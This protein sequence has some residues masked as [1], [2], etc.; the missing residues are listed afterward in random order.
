MTEELIFYT[1][2]MSRGRV[3]RWMLEETGQSYRTELLDYATTMKAPD[4]LNVNPMGKVPTIRHGDTVV[5]E[6]AAICAYLAD[7]FPEAGLA[8]PPGDRLRGRY[9]RWLFFGAGPVEAATTNKALGFVLPAG[10]ERLAGYG[11][12]TDVVR[13]LEGAVSAGDY[14]VGD[15]FS[16]ADVYLGSQIGWGMMFGTIEKQ[17]AFERYWARISARPAAVRARDIDDTLAAEQRKAAGVG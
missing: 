5:T 16:A 11:S 4:Y 6:A 17:P 7:A 13:A 10:R 9:Y 12:F 2:P 15:R 1:H 8:P 3:V 14:L